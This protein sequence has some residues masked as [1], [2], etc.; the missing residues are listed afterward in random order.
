MKQIFIQI[1][2]E[3]KIPML[4]ELLSSLTFVTS[5]EVKE[6]NGEAITQ[7]SYPRAH[8]SPRH[9]EMCQEE[10]AFESMKPDLIAQ[11]RGQFIALF[12]Q[13]VID[14]DPDEL[15]LLARIEQTHPDELVLIRQVVETPESPLQFR[16]PRLMREE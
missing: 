11:Y 8:I 2:D 15:A 14:H 6:S 3:Q 16:S 4:V 5:L 10:A 9:P 7:P 12:Q 13:Q 1:E